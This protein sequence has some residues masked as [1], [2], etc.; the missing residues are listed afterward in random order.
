MCCC[1]WS[2]WNLG[3][4]RNATRKEIADWR[5]G[6]ARNVLCAWGKTGA[7]INVQARLAAEVEWIDCQKHHA[8][9]FTANE[10]RAVECKMRVR[11]NASVAAEGDE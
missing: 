6:D 4:G 1:C 2:E 7:A 9:S 5:R 8:R 11:E 3:I 10:H